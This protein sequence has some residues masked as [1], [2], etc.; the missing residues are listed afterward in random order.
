MFLSHMGSS[1][2]SA[3]SLSLFAVLWLMKFSI[4]L[5]STSAK[6]SMVPLDKE[7]ITGIL[8]LFLLSKI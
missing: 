3:P 7:T 2:F 1:S 5:L 4:A 8:S 6:V